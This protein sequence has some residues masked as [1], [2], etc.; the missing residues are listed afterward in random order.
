MILNGYAKYFSA[1][2]IFLFLLLFLCCNNP[3]GDDGDR[4]IKTPVKYR[5]I[6]VVVPQGKTVLV[7]GSGSAGVFVE[8]RSIVLSPYGIA[9]Y[10][11]TWELW[12]EVCRWARSHGYSIAN[13]GREGHGSTGTGNPNKGWTE[14]QRKARPATSMTWRDAIVWCNAYSEMSG[15][16]PVY[17]EGE[18]GPVLRQSLN[19]MSHPPATTADLP[20]AKAGAEGYRLPAEAEWEFAARGGDQNTAGW[21]Y[22]YPGSGTIDSVAWYLDNS[23][24]LGSAHADYGAHPAGSKGDGTGA[25]QLSLY[26]MGGNVSEYCRDWYG[27]TDAIA[28]D[29]AP[30]GP[31]MGAFA[32]RVM[33]GG[34]WNSYAADCMV[35]S[36][37]YTRPWIGSPYVGFRVARSLGAE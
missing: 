19:I 14:A 1:A 25:N 21:N 2:G 5:E 20:F 34:G 15:L 17:Y 12:D 16:E 22:E 7:N 27:D 37:N 8:Y 24:A 29:T 33:R 35:T 36:R 13:P 26:D 3:A 9:R 31:D 4:G 18:D 11:T 23:S 6:I 30:E 10:E 28:A 32:H